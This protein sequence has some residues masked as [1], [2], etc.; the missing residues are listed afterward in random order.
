MT[1]LFE[2]LEVYKKAMNF[3]AEVAALTEGFQRGYRHLAGQLNRVA[4]S[5]A[6]NLAEGCGR[7]TKHDGTFVARQRD[8]LIVM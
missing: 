6:T 5:I 2:N 7:I 4:I 1:F 3:A 8:S